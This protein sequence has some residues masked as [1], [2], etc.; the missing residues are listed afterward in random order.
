MTTDELITQAIHAINTNQPRMANLYMKNALEQTDKRRR[1]LNPL[2]WK[3]RDLSKALQTF[4][5]IVT[6]IGERWAQ[7]FDALARSSNESA[8]SHAKTNYALVGPGK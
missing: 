7:A 5:D 8:D 4:G 2:G 6:L 3:V 1:E